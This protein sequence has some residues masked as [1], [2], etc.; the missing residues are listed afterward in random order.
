M[1]FLLWCRGIS[2][3]IRTSIR[4]VLGCAWKTI[5]DELVSMKC[6]SQVTKSVSFHLFSSFH[7][8]SFSWHTYTGAVP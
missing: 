2:F 3:R 6:Q 7:S 8:L 4:D 5:P 1:G